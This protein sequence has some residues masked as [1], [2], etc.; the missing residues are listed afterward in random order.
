METSKNKG[1]K[2]L[3]RANRILAVQWIY[4]CEARG[5]VAGPENFSALCA[6][7]DKDPLHFTFAKEIVALLQKN[8]VEVDAL[9]ERFA[10]N[11]NL[12]RI[13]LVDLCIIRLG[14][15]EL[16]YRNDIPPIVAINE[17]IELGKIFSGEAS[18][19]FINGILDRIKCTLSRSLRTA[20]VSNADYV[21][22]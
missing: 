6:L 2:S 10:T 19:A 20:S 3:R 17:A 14:A 21:N 9:I 5:M 4:M 8:L 15:C 22:Q 1:E 13:A 18:K 7:L 16:L 11:W 12:S